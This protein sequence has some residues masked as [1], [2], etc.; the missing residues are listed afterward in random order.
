M[1]LKYLHYQNKVFKCFWNK[2]IWSEIQL[3]SNILKLNQNIRLYHIKPICYIGY[4]Q[5]LL[6]NN[7]VETMAHFSRFFDKQKVQNNSI[8][9]KR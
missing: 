6:L 2:F 5:L 3:K 4:K 8:Y 7:F 1:I 9:L